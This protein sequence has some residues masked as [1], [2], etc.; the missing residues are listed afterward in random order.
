[1]PLHEGCARQPGFAGSNLNHGR[2]FWSSATEWN[3]KDRIPALAKISLIERDYQH[4]MADRRITQIR[5][6]YLPSTRQRVTRQN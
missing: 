4:P 5:G 6:P 2:S 1:M 3:D